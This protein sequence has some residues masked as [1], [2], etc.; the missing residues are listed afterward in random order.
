MIIKF[1]QWG[2]SMAYRVTKPSINPAAIVKG[3]VLRNIFK[4]SLKPILKEFNR[5]KVLGKSREAPR[6]KP[7]AAS[8]TIPKISMEP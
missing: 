3:T 6:I 4:P 8:I 5:E 2:I 7:E 1:I